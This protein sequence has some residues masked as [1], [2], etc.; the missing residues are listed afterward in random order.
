[1]KSMSGVSVSASSRG[2]PFVGFL[3]GFAGELERVG[4]SPRTIE[5]QVNLARHL[6]GW[7]AAEGLAAADLDGVV[8]ARFLAVRRVTYSSMRSELALVPLLAFLRRVGAG[9]PP[10]VVAAPADPAA[11][12]VERFSRYLAVERGLG[13]ATVRSYGSQVSPFV[14]AFPPDQD[15]VV[16]VTAR[17]VANF[18]TARAAG[19]R[20]GSVAVGANALR[21]L[22]RWMWRERIMPVDLS[23]SVGAVCRP[24]GATVPKALNAS[25]VAALRAELASGPE[26]LRNEA[27]VALMLRLGLRAG[28]VAGLLLDDIR[29][30]VG[31]IVVRGKRGRIDE[32]P[33][34][35]DVGELLVVY[36]RDGRPDRPDRHVFLG[37]DAPHR[38]LAGSAVTSVA[39]RALKQARIVGS[40][41]AHRL[42][43]TAACEVLAGG[44]GLIEAG[45]LLRHSGP[46]TTAIYAR[47]DIAALATIARPWPTAGSV[48]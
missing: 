9:V 35:V 15:G 6:S 45:Q 47:A 16:V 22:L 36:L 19:C 42:R 46:Q 14:T 39:A 5:T 40:G 33:I 32:L 31:V 13:A 26:R 2:G 29:W 28:E 18:V 4:Y 24:A 1:M 10:A 20:P 21:A 30:R 23:G 11:L 7:L 38:A 34:P 17:Q 43:H 41:A 37:V 48:R 3:D 25:E 8:I 44:G 27:M 12:L